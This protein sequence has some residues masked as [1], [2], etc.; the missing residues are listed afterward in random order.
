MIK[1]AID[2]VAII[3]IFKKKYNMD[4]GLL[5][6]VG[7]TDPLAGAKP[8]Q[9]W[10]VLIIDDEKSIH[11]I[12]CI[13]LKDFVF[14]DREIIFL[15]AYTAAEA[16][17]CFA[18][19]PDT[20][21]MLVDV[22]METENAGLNFVRHVREELKNN[23]VQIVIRTGQ[24]GFAPENEVIAKYQINS[25]VSK[26]EV[27]AQK[28]VS[29]VTTSLRTYQLSKQ[30]ERELVKRK[31]A[32]LR[33]RD[34]NI[35]L[36]KK[37]QERTRELSRANQLKS[38][39]LA[40][41]SHEIRT[42]MNG[43][44][45]IS[46]ILKEEV[47]TGK[48]HELVSIVHSSANT[49]LTLINDILDLSKIEAGQLKFEIRSFSVEK[50]LN[51]I[52]SLFS[53]QAKE[54]QLA[55]TFALD[56]KVPLFLAGDETRIKQILLNL[57]GNAIKF[58]R[59][60]FVKISVYLE[61]DLSTHVLL[62]FEVEDTGP[63]VKDSFKAHLFDKFS[64]QDSSTTRK[65]G[66]TGLG[67]AISKQL[68][69]MMGGVIDVW[70]KEIRGAVFKVILKIKKQD[71]ATPGLMIEEDIKKKTRM[72]IDQLSKMNPRIL[73]AEDNPINQKVICLILEKM[74]LRAEIVNDGEAVL[75]KLRQKEYDLV[76]L[77]IHM[78][79][80]D[81]L[82]TTRIIRDKHSS[83]LQKNIPIIALTALAMEA[84]AKHC[85]EAGMDQFLTKPIHPEK[86]LFAIAKAMGI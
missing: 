49:L 42:P 3:R 25:Y 15:S 56:P 17:V 22:V 35:N 13:A 63:G 37:I 1:Q 74:N 58:T 83:V 18:R 47:L 29:L 20:A 67:L 57:T 48:Q 26:T 78:P 33:L 30:L 65:F 46:N 23:L 55:L 85:L 34:L 86:L 21:L 71:A 6:F 77:D 59:E 60:G 16:K 39:F 24:P 61:K 79:R 27:T 19:N 53:L 76:F 8:R 70:N 2:Q 10:K 31:Q 73:L 11:D 36:E 14:D 50:L 32:E 41:M 44:I 54:Q 7:D 69:Q 40:N 72:V 66:G 45:G 75:E 84:D 64:Q 52:V 5:T 51:E 43:I 81:G 38:Q 68:A 62:A 80:L 82:E 28:L 12:T 9:Y 4:D